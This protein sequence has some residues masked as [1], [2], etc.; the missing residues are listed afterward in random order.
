[1]VPPL[2][3]NNQQFQQGQQAAQQVKA[4]QVPTGPAAIMQQGARAGAVAQAAQTQQAVQ[5]AGK[6][7]IEA[8][9]VQA[10]QD[11]AKQEAR[12]MDRIETQ[13]SLSSQ[14]RRLA[15]F[16][17]EMDNNMM[18]ERRDFSAKKRGQA[19]NNERQLADW[20][21]ANS[22]DNIQLNNRLR[23]M[24]QASNK[25]IQTLEI[26]Q[27]RIMIEEERLSKAERNA[28]SRKQKKKLANMKAAME[29]KIA[30]EKAKA[31]KRGGMIKSLIGVGKI[32]AGTAMV[33]YSGGTGSAAGGMLIASGAGDVVGGAEQQK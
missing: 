16:A 4:G 27:Q 32:V 28:K 6:Q 21:L 3:L 12:T 26:I 10:R 18:E 20:T 1:M 25:K 14:K 19:F 30:R 29:R 31:R 9:N 22:R 17:Q 13:R 8:Q 33:L 2:N 11:I 7:V 24:Q 23:E 15:K 5:Q